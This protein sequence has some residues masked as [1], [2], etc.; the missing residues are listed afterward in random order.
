MS[1]KLN[2]DL[3]SVKSKVSLLTKYNLTTGYC[4]AQQTAVLS[5]SLIL[6]FSQ[7]PDWESL[8]LPNRVF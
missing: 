5:F 7:P 3:D 1:A 2:V 6:S 8:A 4:Q